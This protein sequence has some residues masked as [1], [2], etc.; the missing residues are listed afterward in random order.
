MKKTPG[1]SSNG[2]SMQSLAEILP[3]KT[4]LLY[5]WPVV[6]AQEQQVG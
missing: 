6:S 5:P 3:V 2:D 4:S 1:G